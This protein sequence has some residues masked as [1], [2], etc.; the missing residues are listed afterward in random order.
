MA[1]FTVSEFLKRLMSAQWR[2]SYERILDFVRYF[3]IITFIAVFI[4]T[5]SECQPFDHYWQVVPD[6]GP[7]CRQGY[8]QLIA[9][10]V[11]DIIT[12]VILVIFPIP[13]VLVSNMRL[14]RKIS[15]T[16]LFSMSLFM[17]A[18]TSYRVPSVINR[19]G[20]QQY[21]TLLAS[22][23]ILAAAAITN[24][25]VI[26]SFIRDRGVKK[27]KFKYGSVSTKS[28]DR[29]G[30]RRSTFTYQS[31]GSDADLVGGLGMR[32]GPEFETPHGSVPRP[33]PVALPA[34][35]TSDDVM[36]GGIDPNWQFPPK[37]NTST[38]S[39]ISFKDPADLEG[40][41]N[42]VDIPLRTHKQP[43]GSISSGPTIAAGKISFFDVGGL[44]DATTPPPSTPSRRTSSS[45][46]TQTI[47]NDFA[48]ASPRTHHPHRNN[49]CLSPHGGRN[50]A[51]SE[52]P[53]M[54]RRHS[55]PTRA[56]ERTRRLDSSAGIPAAVRE[57]DESRSPSL[58]LGPPSGVPTPRLRRQESDISLQDAGGLLGPSPRTIGASSSPRRRESRWTNPRRP[59]FRRALPSG[60]P[61]PRLQRQESEISLQDPGGLLDLSGAAQQHNSRSALPPGTVTGAQGPQIQL[62]GRESEI[63]PH[64]TGGLPS[65]PSEVSPPL[66]SPSPLQRYRSV[67]PPS[68][69]T[70][71]APRHP[72]YYNTPPSPS[73]QSPH[74][75]RNDSDISLQDVGG[76]LGP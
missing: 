66:P 5:L 34:S 13:M 8:A 49:S 32:L 24:S 75:R 28:M 16:L 15:L 1:K 56:F 23:E 19:H 53:L 41:P 29:A 7:K 54:S 25:I 14:K 61:T 70:T 11:C 31:W 71:T 65:M 12:D 60:V 18:I 36:T 43:S 64:D 63:G 73:T 17:V 40:D 68:P 47:T 45:A 38:P 72:T 46:F 48:N 35:F 20:A 67:S 6:P 33:A 58:R 50:E 4:A 57:L 2:E 42:V 59:G 51:S 39:S 74:I 55:S 9:M 44:L 21:R 26:G 37:S 22:L 30:T 62:R 3:L 69:T 52:T 27:Q 76:L 10:G